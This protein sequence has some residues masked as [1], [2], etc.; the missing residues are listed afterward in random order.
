MSRTTLSWS[1]MFGVSSIVSAQSPAKLQLINFTLEQSVNSKPMPVLQAATQAALLL[2]WDNRTFQPGK[3]FS[4]QIKGI[5]M[6]DRPAVITGTLAAS[7]NSVFLDDGVIA[8]SVS[9]T[10][11]TTNN[12]SP[13]IMSAV[14]WQNQSCS[15]NKTYSDSKD[16]PWPGKMDFS[17]DGGCN[18][19]PYDL[20]NGAISLCGSLNVSDNQQ[21]GE[22]RINLCSH[23]QLV[24][25]NATVD[26]IE[27]VQTIQDP[28]NSIPLIK[29]KSAVARVFLKLEGTNVERPITSLTGSLTADGMKSVPQLLNGDTAVAVQAGLM[30]ENVA[31]HSLNYLLPLDWTLA[32]Q[33]NLSASVNSA[34]VTRSGKASVS[35][36]DY[37]HKPFSIAYLLVCTPDLAGKGVCPGVDNLEDMPKFTRRIFPIAD[38]GLTYDYI[39]ILNWPGKLAITSPGHPPK[40]EYA[41]FTL[42]LLKFYQLTNLGVDQMLAWLPATG[43]FQSHLG[44]ITQSGFDHINWAANWGCESWEAAPS[45]GGGGYLAEGLGANLGLPATR[46]QIGL[47]GFDP[48]GRR[49]IPSDTDGLMALG[50]WI[51]KFEYRTLVDS[52]GYPPGSSPPAAASSKSTRTTAAQAVALPPVY[53]VVSGSVSADGSTGHLDSAYNTTGGAAPRSTD[54]A[55]AYCLRFT[56]SAGDPIDYCFTPPP[57]DVD[58]LPFVVKAPYPAATTRVALRNGSVELAALS[59]ASAP[60]NLTISGPQPGDSW[61]GNRTISWFGSDPDG[62]SLTYSVLYSADNGT[63]WIPLRVDTQDIQLNI[64]CSQLASAGKQVWFRVMATSGLSTTTAD[65]GPIEIVQ[66]P[67]VES[68]A[69][70]VDFGNLKVGLTATRTVALNNTGTGPV[71]VS[72]ALSGSTA[73]VLPSPAQGIL[74]L[75]GGTRNLPVQFAPSATGTQKGTLT[76]NAPDSAPLTVALTGAAFASDVPSIEVSPA[77]LDF[78]SVPVKQTKDLKVVVS[79]KGAAALHVSSFKTSTSTFSVTAPSTLTQVDAGKSVELT[80]RFAPQISGPASDTLTL[81]TDDPAKPKVTVALT[82]TA[83]GGTPG[84]AISVAP[85]SLDFGSVGSGQTKD[86]ALTVRNT[87][88]AVLNV[89]AAKTGSTSFTWVSPLTPFTVAAGSQ[90]TVIVRF[91]P[92]TTDSFSSAVV[93]TS[94]DPANGSLSVPLSGIGTSVTGAPS[95]VLNPSSLDFGTVTVGQ[96]KDVTASIQNSGNAQLNLTAVSS[97]DPQFTWVNPTL[98]FSV[99]VSSAQTVTLRFKPASTGKQQTAFVIST[100]DPAH[101]T[102]G[103]NAQGVGDASTSSGPVL[104]VLTPA[105]V[106]AG[107]AAFTLTISGANFV[108]QSTVKWNGSARATTFL[109]ASQ[110]QAAIPASDV[111]VAG[112]AN[113]TV[114]GPSGVSTALAIAIAPAGVSVLINQVDVRSCTQTNAF[115]TAL[116]RNGSA[117]P[118]LG[119]A[120]LK[121]FEDGQPIACNVGLASD[122][123]DLAMVIVM[124]VAP[125][126]PGVA[127]LQKAFAKTLI[128]AMGPSERAAIVQAGATPTQ[129]I[130]FT[131]VQ[132]A[133]T[134]TVDQMRGSPDKLGVYDAVTLAAQLA[135]QQKGRRGAVVVLTGT[136]SSTGD[137]ATAASTLSTLRDSGVPLFA[138]SMSAGQDL[139]SFFQQAALDTSGWSSLAQ[140]SYD[141]AGQTLV[142]ILANQYQVSYVTN[143]TAGKPHTVGVSVTAS[144]GQA[145]G[146]RTYPRCGL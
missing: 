60:P 14:I 46:D 102:I 8:L 99:P 90:S 116:D 57:F 75:A 88:T 138:I 17:L 87:G 124:D 3:N 131:N 114:E 110:V 104:T 42:A 82:G 95:I 61:T 31:D 89:S 139:M 36:V 12:Y 97:L 20:T 40:L 121:C 30:N 44:D 78:G 93:I 6:A 73:F 29:G 37:W 117:I 70:A 122:A 79:N 16:G 15:Q 25:S 4:V 11:T 103:L 146:S 2:Q 23:Y 83:T 65:V 35:F 127:D 101:A 76:I 34:G 137:A 74:I 39:G 59:A 48:I 56:L 43:E 26:H 64:D 33:L 5:G 106:Q 77:T 63:H 24:T 107:I 18:Q 132:I 68:P 120:N 66:K 125:A 13:G 92:T 62:N 84:P 19:N 112:T 145:S 52:G 123:T 22:M 142:G 96:T 53:L 126:V 69:T 119:A 10:V 51:S 58:A 27:V 105:Q 54:P 7:G 80:L 32:D 133:L 86:L 141:F 130:G 55:D 1:L 45:C 129:L 118:S 67:K 72:A 144:Q 113:V 28:D 41:Q 9:G 143:Q 111:A 135:A 115:L 21:T 50:S 85:T 71:K 128:G 109:S 100:N 134:T 49:F 81:A 108:P 136:G 98:P 91:A 47:P 38:D 140:T 94:D